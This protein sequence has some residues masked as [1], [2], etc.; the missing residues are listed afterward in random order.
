MS[1]FDFLPFLTWSLPEKAKY[2]Y[3]LF[4]EDW[5]EHD[6]SDFIKCDRTWRKQSISTLVLLILNKSV[7]IN[8]LIK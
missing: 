6:L 3:G 7:L 2:D 5:W 4:F 1:S 8:Y